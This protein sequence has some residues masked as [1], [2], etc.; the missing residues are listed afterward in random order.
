MNSRSLY[1]LLFALILP[2]AGCHKFE[3]PASQKDLSIIDGVKVPL[4]SPFLESTIAI[5]NSAD[6][7]ECTGVLIAQD[8]VLTAAHCADRKN[9]KHNVIHDSKIGGQR[10]H[11]RLGKKVRI[12]S[13]WKDEYAE[14]SLDEKK[15]LG[16]IAVIQFDG[17]PFPNLKPA[18][19]LRSRS[20]LKKGMTVVIAGFGRF[21]V[22][23]DSTSQHLRAAQAFLLDKS[24]SKTELLMES[25]LGRGA[26]GGDSGGPAFIH[27]NGQFFVIGIASRKSDYFCQADTIYTSV[28]FYFQW[29]Q[30]IIKGAS[31][32]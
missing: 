1:P 15:D 17:Q 3:S 32:K 30:K 13:A 14:I 2:L 25:H 22:D 12:A 10:G 7:S 24:F 8:L 20:L 29:I 19:L 9:Q 23:S 4:G 11:F 26:C 27:S 28:P 6:G 16:D 31:A 18:P 5:S 21:S